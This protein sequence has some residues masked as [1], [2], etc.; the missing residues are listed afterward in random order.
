MLRKLL[1]KQT[2]DDQDN[3]TQKKNKQENLQELVK[4]LK[5]LLDAV[6]EC[7]CLAS[8]HISKNETVLIYADNSLLEEFIAQ[9]F[10]EVHYTLVIVLKN[11]NKK[12]QINSKLSKNEIIFISEK[13]VFSIMNKINKVFMDSHAIMHDG[14]VMNNQ[15]SYNIAIVAKEFAVPL[16]IIAPRYKFT[17]LYAFAQD[18]FN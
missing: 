11:E 13:S 12:P 16:F 6:S 4:K 15:G 17:P 10:E 5:E 9:T 8:L 3:E 1:T 14:A 18:T 2:E 7:C